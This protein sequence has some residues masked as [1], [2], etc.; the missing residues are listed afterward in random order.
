MSTTPTRV[1][2]IWA[3]LAISP[4]A[5]FTFQ[6]GWG[7]T[8]RLAC[9]S[10]GPPLGPLVGALALLACGGAA[11]LAW[12]QARADSS[13]PNAQPRVFLAGLA[14][15]LA[16]VFGLAIIWQALATVLSPPCV[17]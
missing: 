17:R 7:M 14:I 15:G 6:Q 3:A 5:W 1:A 12:P 13:K 8:V 16:A 2:R 11:L 4:A 9:V 10:S